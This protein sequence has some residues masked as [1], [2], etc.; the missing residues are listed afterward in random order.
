MATAAS[1]AGTDVPAGN[2][3]VTNTPNG[4]GAPLLA[5]ATNA[6]AAVD[7]VPEGGMVAATGENSNFFARVS[8]S[9]AASV[10]GWISVMYLTPALPAGFVLTFAEK[11]QL[12]TILA[13]WS[14]ATAGAPVYGVNSADFA[15]TALADGR[16]A[17]IVAAFQRWRGGL[18]TDGIVDP[19]TQAAIT[20][21][22]QQ[23]LT[24]QANTPPGA[25]PGPNPPAPPGGL[26]LNEPPAGSA[27]SSGAGAGFALAVGAA[28]LAL[29]LLEQK[30][31]AGKR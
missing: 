28:L 4:A 24:G 13:A 25:I 23:A 18:R 10:T 6:A 12:R 15:Q 1:P 27:P 21:W 30:K 5:S 14:H 3:L 8:P 20:G 26:S 29:L 31:K 22:A 7:T 9:G 16:Q 2:Y 19:A 11:L 17:T